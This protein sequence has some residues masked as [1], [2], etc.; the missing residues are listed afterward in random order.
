MSTLKNLVKIF[1]NSYFSYWLKKNPFWQEEYFDPNHVCRK[2]TQLFLE[3]FPPNFCPFP[4]K[5]FSY[6]LIF[7]ELRQL[8][9]KF[10]SWPL[11]NQFYSDPGGT[12]SF[13]I[14]KKK[15]GSF[16]KRDFWGKKNKA[17]VWQ[18]LHSWTWFDLQRHILIIFL[19]FWIL[20]CPSRTQ[21]TSVNIID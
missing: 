8:F 18:Y 6:V 16:P 17:L 15:V 9:S 12:Q 4:P 10:Q 5:I 7:G 14:N 19:F 2:H 21:V 1:V 3:F 13:K 11:L 20:Y